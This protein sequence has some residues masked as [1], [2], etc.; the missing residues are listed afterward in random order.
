M[1]AGE[2]N[3]QTELERLRRVAVAARALTR[4]AV[5]FGLHHE[6]VA[7]AELVALESALEDAGYGLTDEE[8]AAVA[9][10]G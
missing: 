4:T 2:S 8:V 1:S 7:E 5:D 6:I 9:R 3:T 10:S